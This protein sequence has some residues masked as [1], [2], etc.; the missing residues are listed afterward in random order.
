MLA[1]T[2]GICALLL[3]PMRLWKPANGAVRFYWT[4]FWI[5]LCG[6]SAIAGGVN[7]V[8]LM[9]EP[10][11]PALES[12]LNVLPLLSAAFVVAG[13]FH[14]VGL[15]VIKGVFAAVRRMRAPAT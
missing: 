2:A 10:M 13:W 11:T 4:G 14:L 3:L 12:L 5:I 8:L 1:V 7:V 9:G 15:G 6:I